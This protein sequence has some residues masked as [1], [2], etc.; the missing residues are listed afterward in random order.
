MEIVDAGI[1]TRLH[2]QRGDTLT[3]VDDRVDAPT[4][5]GY[6]LVRN[7]LATTDEC[8]CLKAKAQALHD[9]KIQYQYIPG[10]SSCGGTGSANSNYAA[11]CILKKCMG[12]GVTN[13]MS[14]GIFTPYGWNHRVKKCVDSVVYDPRRAFTIPRCVCRKWE[15][16]DGDWCA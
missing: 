8:N 6:V 16:I 3:L 15:T 4:G 1:R 5:G 14:W 7:W 11:N 13:H 12:R 2:F 9:A 10:N